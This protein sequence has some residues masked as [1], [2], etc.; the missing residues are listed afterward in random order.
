MAEQ[1]IEENTEEI[2]KQEHLSKAYNDLLD[3]ISSS[4][5]RDFLESFFD[6]LI[7]PG[8]RKAIAERWLLV[9][10]L[11]AGCTQREIARRYN[12]SLCKITRGSRELQKK[13][14]AFLKALSMV[15]K[16]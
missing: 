7:T 4:N 8:E 11:K 1:Q 9:K 12:M 6:S 13:D 5:D 16:E 14:S 2:E 10:E 3:L 15:E